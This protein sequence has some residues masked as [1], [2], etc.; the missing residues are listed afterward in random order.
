VSEPSKLPARDMGA[1]LMAVID[2]EADATDRS[3]VLAAVAADPRLGAEARLYELTG[4]SLG[5]LFDGVLAQP[6]PGQLLHTV[7]TSDGVANPPPVKVRT[8]RASWT[9]WLAN[10]QMPAAAVAACALAFAAGTALNLTAPRP[11]QAFANSPVAQALT[12]TASGAER[13]I[14]T[15]AGNLKIKVIETFR[16]HAGAACREYEAQG[17][18]GPRQFAVACFGGGVWNLKAQLFGEARS[19]AQTVTA[20]DELGTALDDIAGRL[21]DGDSLAPDAESKLIAKGWAAVK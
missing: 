4:R 12:V 16:D 9:S 2:G 15:S 6:V 1:L 5:R 11:D 14:A 3:R 19:G 20:G 13:D 21:R 8:S 17:A 10:W 7:R 18:T